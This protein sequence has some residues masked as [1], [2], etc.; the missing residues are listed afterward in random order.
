MPLQRLQTF[1]FRNLQDVKIE[2][3]SGLQ[4]VYGDNASG[5]TSLLDAMHLLCSGKSFI[6]ASPRKLIQFEHDSFSINGDIQYKN[7]LREKLQFRWE[8]SRIK[9]M[10]NQQAIHRSSNYAAIQPVQAITPLSY[11]LLDDSPDI[12]RRFIDW[13]VFHVKHDYIEIWRKFQ[14]ALAQR[15]AM[16]VAGTDSRTLTAWSQEYVQLSELVDQYRAEYIDE[17][18]QRLKILT[19]LFLPDD[20]VTINYQR[21]WG[22]EGDL[23]TILGNSF[24][25]DTERHF[26]YYGPQRAELSIRMNQKIARDVASRGQKKLITFALYLTQAQIQQNIG[27]QDGLLLIDDLPSELDKK[28]QHM[29]MDLLKDLPS[30]VILSCIDLKQMKIAEGMVKKLFHVKQGHVKEVVQ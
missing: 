13:G 11:K 30:Q 21:G 1:H 28:H 25:R 24:G 17:F 27:H 29:V 10:V 5:K 4:I 20:S 26:T 7:N 22:E 6:G 19:E 16:L 3:N 15:N 8:D 12:R 14:R 2:L 23:E 9:L 18:S